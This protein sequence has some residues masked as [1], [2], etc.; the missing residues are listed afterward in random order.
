VNLSNKYS[1]ETCPLHPNITCFHHCASDLHFKLNRP[2]LLVWA[3]AI[4]AEC[5][6]YTKPS[7]SSPMFRESLALKHISKVAMDSAA[8]PMTPMMPFLSPFQYPQFSMGY[9][10]RVWYAIS[11][12]PL[13]CWCRHGSHGSIHPV[14]SASRT[15]FARLRRLLRHPLPTLQ[16]PNSVKC[17]T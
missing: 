13:L 7:I 4:K 15:P 8:A 6:L 2:Q 12:P 1:L 17:M 16:S 3:K 5:A 10:W 14:T 9:V 11:F